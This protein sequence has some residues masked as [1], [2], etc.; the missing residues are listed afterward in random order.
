M[1]NV[2]GGNNGKSREERG[3]SAQNAD[4]GGGRLDMICDLMVI[5]MVVMAV[6]T[7]DFS[8]THRAIAMSGVCIFVGWCCY[9]AGVFTLHIG[10]LKT[11]PRV[12]DALMLMVVI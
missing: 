6:V 1:D 7:I 2:A 8:S 5:V 12:S 4:D 11:A 10:A 3:K 9:T